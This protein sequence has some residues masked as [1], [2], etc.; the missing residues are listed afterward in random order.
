MLRLSAVQA[1]KV[2]ASRNFRLKDAE[3]LGFDSIDETTVG[4]IRDG[5]IDMYAQVD[6]WAKVRLSYEGAL[7]ESYRVLN[8][9]V[10]DWVEDHEGDLKKEINPKLKA[11]LE[12]SY[13]DLDLSDLDEDFDDY[14]WEDQ[15]DYMPDV[16]EDKGTIDFQIELVIDIDEP[17][18]ED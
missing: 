15:V 11:Y 7:P 18:D 4:T 1:M 12:K 17:E 3:F 9:A 8:A 10:M 14:I 13:D 5:D 6:V 2:A 16:D